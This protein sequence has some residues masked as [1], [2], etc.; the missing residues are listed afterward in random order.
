MII[1][2]LRKLMAEGGPAKGP[3]LF[4][5]S[6]NKHGRDYGDF[7]QPGPCNDLNSNIPGNL[8]A[9]STSIIRKLPCFW[10]FKITIV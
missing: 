8:R 6:K 2:R 9:E 10:I 1:N 4:L 3:A 5:I 7:H